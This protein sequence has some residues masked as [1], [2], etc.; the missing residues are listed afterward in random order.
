M[1]LLISRFLLHLRSQRNFSAHTLRAYESDLREFLGF[2]RSRDSLSAEK[3]DRLL[4]RAYMAALQDGPGK[5]GKTGKNKKEKLSRNSILRKISSLRSFVSHLLDENVI[6]SD[7]FLLLPLPRKEKRLPKF[8]SEGEVERLVDSAAAVTGRQVTGPPGHRAWSSRE[9]D[10]ALIELMYSSGLRRAEVSSMNVGDVDFLSG[11]V[12]VFGKGSRERLVPAGDKALEALNGYLRARPR[13]VNAGQPLF[14]NSKNKRLSGC[15]VALIINKL[16]RKARFARPVTPH[17]LR[18]SFATHLLDH[19]CDLRSVQEML[20]HKSL[21]TT[22]IYTH[23]S[24]ERLKKVYDKAH[25]RS[26]GKDSD[27]L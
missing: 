2:C 23:V 6:K 10:L 4:V 5:A 19:G 9:R 3:L 14:L 25:P 1:E 17:C 15:G 16:A 22:Q 26:R 24:L 7:P 21:V 18:H 27:R 11:F 20:G 8:L 13:P 12:R